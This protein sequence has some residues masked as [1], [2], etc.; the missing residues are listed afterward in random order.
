M[1]E[2]LIREIKEISYITEKVGDNKKKHIK[3]LFF[4][5]IDSFIIVKNLNQKYNSK[6]EIKS[7]QIID[8]IFYKDITDIIF[9]SIKKIKLSKKK[10]FAVKILKNREYFI[11]GLSEKSFF[12]FRKLYEDSLYPNSNVF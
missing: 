10:Q 3:P 12:E 8:M 4:A 5:L 7:D 9:P 11:I 6:K 1:K 2:D